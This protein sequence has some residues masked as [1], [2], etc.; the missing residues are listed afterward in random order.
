MGLVRMLRIGSAEYKQV[1]KPK[2]DPAL[3]LYI[4]KVERPNGDIVE[5]FSRVSDGPFQFH[6]VKQ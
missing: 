6:K 4:G 5:V 2:L 1:E 3:S